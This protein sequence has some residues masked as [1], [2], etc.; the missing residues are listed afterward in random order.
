MKTIYFLRHAEAASPEFSDDHSRDLTPNG[1]K[2]VGQ[3]KSFLLNKKIA[4]DF[5]M[6]SAAIRTQET[7]EGIRETLS[8]QDFDVSN[9]YYNLSEEG[10]FKAL[11]DV[12]DQFSSVLYVGHNP[13]ITFTAF[14]LCEKPSV[15]ME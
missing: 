13:G 14:R 5:V 12:D 11:Q 3:L 10:L 1:Q 8:T 9:A 7:L 4:V 15:H 2:Q 6:C